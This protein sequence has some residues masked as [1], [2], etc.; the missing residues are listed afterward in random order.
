MGV[1]TRWVPFGAPAC[2]ALTEVVA[3]IKA[4]DPLAPVT[5]VTPTPA[6]AVRLRRELARRLGGIAV[7]G[8]HALDSLAEMIAA[9]RLGAGTVVGGVDREVVVAAI[10]AELGRA[11]GRFAGI[12]HHRSTWE[13]LAQTVDEVASSTP[14]QRRSIAAAGELAAEVI[15]LHDA[16]EAAVGMGGRIEVLRAA[17][18]QIDDR[19]DQLVALG[20]VV[21]YL[22]GRL[23]RPSA[24]L[25]RDIG[26]RTSLVVIGGLC[27]VEPVDRRAVETVVDLGGS[28]PA[29]APP[30]AAVA[31]SVVSANDVDDEI[32]G[33]IRA[34]LAHAEA[35]HPLHA[36]AIVHPS[37]APYTRSVAELLRS[38]GIP[39]S[40][41][42]T[43][44]LGHTAP[45]RVLL[46]LLDV[47]AHRF[48]RQAVVDLW[49]S[50]VV[51]GADGTP[52]ALGRA[53]PPESPARHRRWAG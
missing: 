53:R 39:F 18:A 24:E 35:G 17:I 3:E 21:V 10:R 29:V 38:G 46:G 23:D 7:V 25:L 5:V 48:A 4:A 33:A 20:P 9:P 52:R 6:A 32:R 8:F 37:G 50:G 12:E 43:E 42:S 14:E 11:P 15:R 45:G 51:V 30:S 36:M 47:A 28:V 44:T 31:T 49:A 2:E 27:G 16:V 34:L 19:P 41:P 1:E 26:A 13:T 22:P 40:G